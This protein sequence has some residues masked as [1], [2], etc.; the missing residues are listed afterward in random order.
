MLKPT[1]LNILLFWFVKYIAFYVLMMFKNKNY[2]LIRLGDLKTGEDWFYYLWIF[3]FLPVICMIV[4]S[5]PVY[6][7]FKKK[8]LIYFALI[9]A[10]VLITEYLFYTW[11]AS[12]TDLMNGV[13]NGIISLLFLVLIFY[14]HISILYQQNTQ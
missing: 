1:V 4:F 3:L 8:G 14:R 5:A 12:Q 13:Y 9:I 2:S 11:S 6:L 7:S 10:V